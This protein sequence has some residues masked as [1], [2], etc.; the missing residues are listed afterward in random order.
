MN[1]EEPERLKFHLEAIGRSNSDVNRDT[2]ENNGIT[3]TFK[4]FTWSGDGWLNNAL[5]LRDSA[6]AVI[7]YKPLERP[8][9]NPTNS[10]AFNIK[11]KVSSITDDSAII[12]KCIDDTGVGF[13]I[14]TQE[15]KMVA[16]GGET[17]SAKFAS[18]E[19]YNIMITSYFDANESSADNEKLN[20][21]MLYLY[22]NGILSGAIEKS[23]GSG[24]YQTNP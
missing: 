18:G 9:V 20:D 23:S 12:V 8:S 15:V 1:I 17:V 4:D 22:I 3:T 11:F 7:N 21:N 13:T 6:R 16:S 19:I 14:S 10:F 2:W 5:R 24:I